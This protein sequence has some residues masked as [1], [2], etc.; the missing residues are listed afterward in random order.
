[1]SQAA[2]YLG[3]GLLL[4]VIGLHGLCCQTHAMRRLIAINIMGSGVFMVLVTLATRGA[5]IDP[6]PHALVVTGLVVAVSA[7]AFALRLAA[8]GRQD[9]SKPEPP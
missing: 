6:L 4:W 7:T 9:T 5:A 2:L 8:P 3:L 1:M